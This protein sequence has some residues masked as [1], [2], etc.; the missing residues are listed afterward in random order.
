MQGDSAPLIDL[1]L[2]V[3]SGTPP[4]AYGMKVD[5]YIVAGAGRYAARAIRQSSHADSAWPNACGASGVSILECTAELME[6]AVPPCPF[7]SR[8]RG[9]IRVNDPRHLGQETESFHKVLGL[10][11]PSTLIST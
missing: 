5:S 8:R 2:Y 7:A 4:Y 6:A 1:R 9:A 3:E 10:L 11:F